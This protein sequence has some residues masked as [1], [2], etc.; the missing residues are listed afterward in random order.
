MIILVILQHNVMAPNQIFSAILKL[1][2]IKSV[3]GFYSLTTLY[4]HCLSSFLKLAFKHLWILHMEFE[5][6]YNLGPRIQK[7]N[8]AF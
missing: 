4:L 7:Q 5:P 1:P 2:K 8:L 6:R 3:N